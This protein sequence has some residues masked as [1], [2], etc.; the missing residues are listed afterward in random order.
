VPAAGGSVVAVLVGPRLSQRGPT[1]VGGAAR[2]Y[3]Q[4]RNRTGEP[5][6]GTQGWGKLFGNISS[7]GAGATGSDSRSW[8]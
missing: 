6:E 8:T 1:L 3:R 5:C 4:S 2:C 7:S